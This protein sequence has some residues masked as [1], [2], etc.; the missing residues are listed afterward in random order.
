MKIHLL[1][2]LHNSI[3]FYDPGQAAEEADVIV[4]AG[5]IAE[6]AKGLDWAKETFEQPIIYVAGNLE[7]YK[8][9]LSGTIDKLKKLTD[10][11]TFVL[12]N[13]EVVLD[14]V[15]FLGATAWTDYTSTGSQ[16]NA[17]SEA[18]ARMNDF[19]LI[20][21]D[22]NE[23]VQPIDFQMRN[24]ATRDWLNNQLAKEFDGKTVVVTHHS[25]STASRN[26]SFDASDFDASFSNDWDDIVQLADVWLHG[27]T[28]YAVDYR[29][30]NARIYSNSYGYRG[31]RTGYKDNLLIEV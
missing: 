24:R 31:E 3:P 1:S 13:D 11:R 20:K 5:D 25:P 27:H 23:F 14:G 7:Y 10:H 30:G 15:R 21:N 8:G 22:T 18:V 17:I 2:D 19:R 12:E 29:L 26:P 4:L 16:T 6:Q 9:S 28:H